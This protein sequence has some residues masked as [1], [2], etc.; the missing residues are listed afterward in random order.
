MV[1]KIG[2]VTPIEADPFPDRDIFGEFVAVVLFFS[3]LKAQALYFI[4]QIAD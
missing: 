3:G 4:G 2:G 1:C